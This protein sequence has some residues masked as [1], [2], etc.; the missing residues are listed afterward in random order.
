MVEHFFTI[1]MNELLSAGLNPKS[2]APRVE[3]YLKE[4]VKMR[5]QEDNIRTPFKFTHIRWLHGSESYHVKVTT[6]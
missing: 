1:S 2:K 6:E 4:V 3:N 5:L